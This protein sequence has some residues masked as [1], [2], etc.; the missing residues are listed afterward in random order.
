LTDATKKKLEKLKMSMA[1]RGTIV[2][3]SWA[4]ENLKS[5]VESF[6][7][8]SSWVPRNKWQVKK[9]KEMME[10][11]DEYLLRKMCFFLSFFYF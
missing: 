7:F 1:K 8:L 9:E 2:C 5:T 6:F 3:G 4:E 11:D 10:K